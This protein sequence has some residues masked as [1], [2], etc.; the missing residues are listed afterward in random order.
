MHPFSPGKYE[1]YMACSGLEVILAAE[2]MALVVE[3]I[4]DKN[5]LDFES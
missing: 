1:F 3:N 2:N 5:T 4:I